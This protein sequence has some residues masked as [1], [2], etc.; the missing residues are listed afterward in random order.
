MSYKE[1]RL[2]FRTDPNIP[3]WDFPDEVKQH[4]EENYVATGLRESVS[5]T[6][7]DDGLVRTYAGIWKDYAAL[8]QFITDPV[9]VACQKDREAYNTANDIVSFWQQDV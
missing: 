3:F 1:T 2:S 8:Q 6:F 5:K 7:S 4:I 9:L